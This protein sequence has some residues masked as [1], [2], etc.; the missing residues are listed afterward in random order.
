VP[1]TRVEVEV[2]FERYFAVAASTFADVRRGDI[3]LYEDA[4]RNIALA[5][6]SGDAAHMFSTRVGQEVLL[7]PA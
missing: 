4:Y 1:G 2:R 6:N 7:S 3:V 5:I